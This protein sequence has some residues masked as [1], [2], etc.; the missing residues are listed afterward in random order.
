MPI[1][2]EKTGIALSKASIDRWARLSALLDEALTL[3]DADREP[4]LA[5]IQQQQ[6]D[7][8]SELA[9]LLKS[10]REIEGSSFMKGSVMARLG[11]LA[12]QRLGDWVIESAVGSGGMGSVWLA[13]RADDRFVGQAAIKLLN[14]SLVGHAG[15]ERFRREGT[16]LAAL[17]HP[18]IARLLDAG[19]SN[20]GQ[21]YLV[22]EY[23]NGISI[24]QFCDAKRLDTRSRILLFLDV[25]AAVSHAHANLIVH[26]DIK[27][28]NVLVTDDGIVKLLDFGIAKLMDD[29]SGGNPVSALT[30]DAGAAMTPAFAAPEQLLGGAITTG[31][32]V[33]S[34]GV[35]LYMLLVGQHPDGGEALSV[36][37]RL[38]MI[39]ET[40]PPLPSE[41]ARRATTT[42]PQAIKESAQMR[43]VTPEKLVKLLQGDLDNIIAC[44]LKKTAGE[45]YPSALAFGDDLRRHLAHLPVTARPD[46]LPYRASRFVRRHRGGV[47]AG[48]LTLAAISA[49]IVGTITQAQRANAQAQLAQQQTLVAQRER[50]RAVNELSYAEA[51]NEFMSFTLSAASEKPLTNIELLARTEAQVATQFE[52]NAGMRARLQYIVGTAYALASDLKR[53]MSTYDQARLSAVKAQD[54]AL[55]AIVQCNQASVHSDSG[56]YALAEELLEKT[57]AELKAAPALRAEALAVCLGAQGAQKGLQGKP[58]ESIAS[59]KEALRVLGTPRLGQM[60]LSVDLHDHL[61]SS[62]SRVGRLD[63][64]VAEFRNARQSL[65]DIGRGQTSQAFVQLNN[66]A[67]VVYRAGQ[68]S[69]AK[70]LFQES[71]DIGVA[72]SGQPGHNPLIEAN[73]ANALYENGHYDD[74]LARFEQALRN[75]DL[76]KQEFWG[77]HILQQAAPVLCATGALERCE[78]SLIE[79]RKRL[80]KLLPAGHH[81]FANITLN[82]GRLA[83]SRGATAEA[84]T[85]FLEAVR[86]FDAAKERRPAQIHAL[87]LLARTEL[88][89]GMSDATG[90]AETAVSK[91]RAL[92]A[93]FDHSAWLGIALLARAV[94]ERGQSDAVA[95]KSTATEALAHLSHTLDLQAPALRETRA[96]ITALQ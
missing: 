80:G 94:V 5:S 26:R 41:F 66:M 29:E 55:A 74:A 48:I 21:P 56:N 14:L 64:A 88:A 70:K 59:A 37:Q 61:A 25:L 60:S 28:L 9:S 53:A 12:G 42:S 39:V 46:S 69:E 78:A 62:Y 45:R 8:A 83:L 81:T 89:L 47:A 77:A 43:A 6:P 33:Y 86:Q 76:K 91:A 67:D 19:V 40:S 34:L 35:L 52:A 65:R 50:E 15:E 57:I 24:S 23:V 7:V 68:F 82:T 85:Y 1:Q 31:T 90:H 54:T 4:W 11:D 13:R 16:I 20:T 87:T 49:G 51:A 22:L 75:S 71:E 18:N 38:K 84:R 3:S 96:L 44:A 63:L 27:P 58:D 17:N 79:S 93:G 36:A 95:A 73:L 92:G 72:L 2:L 30:R 10:R 32:D